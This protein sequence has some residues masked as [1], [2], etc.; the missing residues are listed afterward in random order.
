[1]NQK[2]GLPDVLRVTPGECMA[3]IGAGGKTSAMFQIA[4]QFPRAVISITTHLLGDQG[5]LADR[6]EILRPSDF[7][8][9]TI[10][11]D[12]ITLFT[13]TLD[14][15]KFRFLSP[16][17]KQLK[18]LADLCFAEKIPFFVEADGARHRSIKAPG[19]H[20]P[21]IP[22]FAN[23]VVL[24]A[25]LSVFGK[26]LNEEFVHR[27]EIFARLGNIQ[28]GDPISAESFINVLLHPAGGLKNIPAN[29]SRQLLFTQPDS[30]A[31]LEIGKQ[32]AER[33][34]GVWDRV[35]IGSLKPNPGEVLYTREWV[36]GVVLA[37]GSSIRYG[38][39]KIHEN[40][41]G[42][43]FLR[44]VCENAK[45]ALDEVVVVT[46]ADDQA[47]LN[48]A[49]DLGLKSAVNPHPEDG[50]SS[51][52]RVGMNNINPR[53]SGVI[54]LHADQPQTSPMLLR[55]LREHAAEFSSE[56]IAPLIDGQRGNPVYFD[57][58]TF[59]ELAELQGD[60]GGR[61]IFHR[62]RLSTVDWLDRKQLLD[63]DTPAQLR[64]LLDE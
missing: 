20:E 32:I 6:H 15:Q 4:R 31:A 58:S 59:S 28:L 47:A 39:P 45:L 43:T 35:V 44:N 8:P 41:R 38:K 21:A 33:V 1:M 42:K 34:I 5:S 11:A 50:Q 14:K 23:C 3:I 40:Y 25:G 62:H 63:V 64:E 7:I 55:M 22:G 61:Q 9:P 46:K 29:A 27:P 19:E 17:G 51:S 49:A 30:P 16:T 57:R 13:G 24:V 52:I 18:Q 10:I 12:G 2:K 60:Q 36:S 54:F 48:A 26:P 56:I 53:T 37:A